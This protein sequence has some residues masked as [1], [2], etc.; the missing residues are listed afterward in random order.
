MLLRDVQLRDGRSTGEVDLPVEEDRLVDEDP[1]VHSRGPEIEDWIFFVEATS[2]W[3]GGFVARMTD[4]AMLFNAEVNG[5]RMSDAQ[6]ADARDQPG[7]EPNDAL[8][9]CEMK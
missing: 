5:E 8:F 2:S 7:D 9:V 3:R 6:D 4:G 1:T